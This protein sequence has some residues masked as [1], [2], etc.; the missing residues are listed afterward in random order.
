MEGMPLCRSIVVLTQL[1][2]DE[3]NLRP[4]EPDLLYEIVSMVLCTPNAQ[5]VG[6]T[7]DAFQP[8]VHLEHFA[9]HRLGVVLQ[10]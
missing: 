7:V 8:L 1:I 6:L 9:E 3:F 5:L 10:P 2:M 4:V